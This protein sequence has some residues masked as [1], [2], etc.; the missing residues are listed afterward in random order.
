MI[1]F[2]VRVNFPVFRAN[3]DLFSLFGKKID[4]LSPDSPLIPLKGRKQK[5]E[6]RS[7]LA[8]NTGKLTRTPKTKT[9]IYTSKFILSG[10]CNIADFEIYFRFCN[11]A[12]FAIYCNIAKFNSAI[13]QNLQYIFGLKST[14]ILQILQYIFGSAILQIKI[15]HAI[16]LQYIA[17]Q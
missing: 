6:K 1:Y 2:W 17:V 5:L 16:L 15:L 10:L 3:I 13:L 7:I 4:F 14:A 9:K 12:K 11:I 8:L